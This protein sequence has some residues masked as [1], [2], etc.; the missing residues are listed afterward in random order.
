MSIVIEL[1]IIY[2]Y[3]KSIL[4]IIIDGC[5]MKKN[6]SENADTSMSLLLCHNNQE[7]IIITYMKFIGI[8]IFYQ[9]IPRLIFWQIY[10]SFIDTFQVTV[11]LTFEPRLGRASA[12]SSR[13]AKTASKLVHSFVWNFCH[14]H[15]YTHR[16]TNRNK[17]MTLPRFC[18][19]VKRAH[20]LWKRKENQK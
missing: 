12:V 4:S 16:Q 7:N 1:D 5:K 18:G 14:R 20:I 6:P 17:N 8:F 19:G 3:M 10:S 2:I 15:T 9:M 13:S 11:T